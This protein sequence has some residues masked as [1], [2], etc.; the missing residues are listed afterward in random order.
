MVSFA[1]L[2]IIVVVIAGAMRLGLRSIES[3]EKKI[4]TLERLR[5][6]VAIINSQIQSHNPL[7]SDIDGEKKYYF[8]GSRESLQFSSNYSIWGGQMGY[9]VVKYEVGREDDGKMK[10]NASETFIGTEESR[11]TMLFKSMDD[12]Y[13]EYFY[14]DPTAETGSWTDSWTDETNVPQKIKLHMTYRGKDF[15]MIIPMRV[16]GSLGQPAGTV[17][18]LFPPRESDE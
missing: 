12:L 10:L 4:G 15:S 8:D 14:K 9:V 16:A 6:S 1:L 18:S 3:G 11:E 13:F 5:A 2:G 7:T 17:Q